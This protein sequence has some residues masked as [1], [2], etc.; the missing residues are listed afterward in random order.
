MSKPRIVLL[1][2][3]AIVTTVTNQADEQLSKDYGL[4]YAQT[5]DVMELAKEKWPERFGQIGLK[6]LAN[7]VVRLVMEKPKDV[8]SSNWEAKILSKEQV[9]YGLI[10]AFASYKI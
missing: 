6:D 1:N 2:G 10:D 3:N 7:D 5:L 9:E 4:Y 8:T